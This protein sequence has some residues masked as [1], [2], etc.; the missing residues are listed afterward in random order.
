[1]ALTTIKYG[2]SGELELTINNLDE[3][4]KTFTD[5]TDVKFMLKTMASQAD[6][7]SP[8]YK[9]MENGQIYTTPD[10]KLRVKFAKADF[11]PT[12]LRANTV[13][14]IAIG[15]EF[16]NTGEYFEDEDDNLQ[17]KLKVTQDKVRA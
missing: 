13:Y 14:L 3:L 7:A 4:A 15:V 2:N 1:M 12:K 6:E 8:M 17:R 5:I 16:N 11:S 10:N 9:T